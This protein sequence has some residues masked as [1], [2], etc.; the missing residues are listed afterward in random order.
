MQHAPLALI[1]ARIIQTALDS[2]LNL[3]SISAY[4]CAVITAVSTRCS[5]VLR[6][7]I[8]PFRSTT[9]FRRILTGAQ[10]AEQ[11]VNAACLFGRS[12]FLGGCCLSGGGFRRFVCGG[13]LCCCSFG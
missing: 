13:L 7:L 5:C 12:G 4:F 2:Y 11:V 10:I 9:R 1:K 6:R 3:L 8:I